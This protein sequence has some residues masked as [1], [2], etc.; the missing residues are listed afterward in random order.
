MSV[1][2]MPQA[3]PYILHVRLSSAFTYQTAWRVYKSHENVT[4]AQC[5][6]VF[7][8]FPKDKEAYCWLMPYVLGGNTI[9]SAVL[10]SYFQ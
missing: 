1:A 9:P 7:N 2:C 3:P 5:T 8:C 6:L 4:T 10:F